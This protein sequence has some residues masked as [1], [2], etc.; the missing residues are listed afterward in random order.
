[1][2]SSCDDYGWTNCMWCS[3]S[4]KW[5]SGACMHKCSSCCARPGGCPAS[6]CTCQGGANVLGGLQTDCP[7][8]GFDETLRFQFSTPSASGGG[9]THVAAELRRPSWADLRPRT[10]AHAAAAELTRPSSRSRTGLVLHW[11][12]EWIVKMTRQF[13]GCSPSAHGGGG[14]PWKR[15]FTWETRGAAH[16]SAEASTTVIE[17]AEAEYIRA[18]VLAQGGQ[19][20]AHYLDIKTNGS[21]LR[22]AGG[23]YLEKEVVEGSAEEMWQRGADPPV[24][25]EILQG[26]AKFVRIANARGREQLKPKVQDTGSFVVAKLLEGKLG[27]PLQAALQGGLFRGQEDAM[28][29]ASAVGGLGPSLSFGTFTDKFAAPPVEAAVPSVEPWASGDSGRVVGLQLS[30]EVFKQLRCERG[31]QRCRGSVVAPLNRPCPQ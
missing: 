2:C 1:M 30:D 3:A 9:R 11:N 4:C 10:G 28:S 21:I 6:Y 20:G 23:V 8:P 13:W 14:C 7:P 19:V 24:Q 15:T 27:P 5:R 18:G 29:D 16:G 31:M 25:P 12:Q 22:M 17:L 26:A